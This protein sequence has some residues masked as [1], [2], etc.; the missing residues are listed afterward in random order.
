[1]VLGTRQRSDQF[2]T[3]WLVGHA[4]SLRQGGESSAFVPR[5]STLSQSV[6]LQ[7]LANANAAAASPAA[8]GP[9]RYAASAAASPSYSSAYLNE[10][11]AATPTRQTG[12]GVIDE[13]EREDA[14]IV[15]SDGVSA[16][17]RA[18]YGDVKDTTAGIPD[19]AHVAAAK[20]RRRAALENGG[21]NGGEEDFIAL[22]DSNSKVA[23]YDVEDGGPRRSRRDSDDD[24]EELGEH[25]E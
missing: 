6:S 2:K 18:K 24:D 3:R 15:G 11:K 1:M 12:R 13:Q 17:A 10:L 22:N 14:E 16:L 8:A 4:D 25:D 19:E 5:K 21:Q 23:V 9:S 7:K 20:A